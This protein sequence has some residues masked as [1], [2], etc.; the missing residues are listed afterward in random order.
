VISSQLWTS[1]PNPLTFDAQDGDYAQKYR[2]RTAPDLPM[3]TLSL[4]RHAKS[5]WDDPELD[6]FDR[7]LSKRGTKAASEMG[8]YLAHERLIPDLVLCSGAVRTRA[9][10]ALLLAEI[11]PPAPEIRYENALYLATPAAML[12][13]IQSTDPKRRHVMV[14]G[15]N[16]GLHALA[17]EL[18]GDGERKT[19][20]ALARAFPTGALALLTFEAGEWRGVKTA[21]GRLDRFVVPRRLAS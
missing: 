4:L 1:G 15:H 14:I 12:T 16:P 9:T 10:L 18:V 7:P 8:Q 11:G 13:L 2:R 20:S 19:V 21:A 6:D 3:L 17:L 5:S